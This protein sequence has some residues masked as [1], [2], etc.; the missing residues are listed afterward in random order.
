VLGG[1]YLGLNNNKGLAFIKFPQTSATLDS[2]TAEM[3]VLYDIGKSS[4]SSEDEV[5]Y[6]DF[7]S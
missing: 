7:T 1:T 6:V 3:T 4:S 2:S 5:D